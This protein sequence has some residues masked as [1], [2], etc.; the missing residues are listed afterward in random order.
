MY[1]QQDHD[2]SID[3]SHPDSARW[4]GRRIQDKISLDTIVAG[5]EADERSTVDTWRTH[6]E[7]VG[8]TDANMIHGTN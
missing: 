1:T 4:T 3:I 7:V 6:Q 2:R 5:A 8:L